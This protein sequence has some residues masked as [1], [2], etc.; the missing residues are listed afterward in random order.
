VCGRGSELMARAEAFLP[1]V[2]RIKGLLS[3]MRSFDDARAL[4]A[5][6]RSLEKEC[7]LSHDALLNLDWPLD[8]LSQM[9]A[10]L[11]VSPKLPSPLPSPT[12]A[13]S[14]LLPS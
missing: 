14:P 3:A 13:P 9:E 8:E 10:V 11:Q 12:H 4:L 1:K 2:E 6:A 5:Q 7:G